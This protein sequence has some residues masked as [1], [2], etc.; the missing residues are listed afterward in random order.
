MEGTSLSPVAPDKLPLQLEG[1]SPVN[2]DVVFYRNGVPY[3]N[4]RT[5]RKCPTLAAGKSIPIFIRDIRACVSLKKTY[6]P[7]V[8]F[9]L[10]NKSVKMLGNVPIQSVTICGQWTAT[11]VFQLPNK[12]DLRFIYVK[13]MSSQTPITC[14]VD[15]VVWSNGKIPRMLEENC[16]LLVTGRIKYYKRDN[17]MEMEARAIH[18]YHELNFLEK[19]IA[20]AKFVLEHRR[21]FLA[22]YDYHPEKTQLLTDRLRRDN[23]VVG[24]FPKPPGPINVR[25]VI[26]KRYTITRYDTL[27]N[28][29]KRGRKRKVPKSKFGL[30]EHFI[31]SSKIRILLWILE[32]S[33][34]SNSYDKIAPVFVETR[35]FINPEIRRQ[36]FNKSVSIL[37]KAG[38]LKRFE[39][40][41][42]QVSPAFV[43]AFDA[44]AL[45]LIRLHHMR[46][47]ELASILEEAEKHAATRDQFQKFLF[48]RIAKT[49]VFKFKLA[50]FINLKSRCAPTFSDVLWAELNQGI[51]P[52]QDGFSCDVKYNGKMLIEWVMV[53]KYR[54][55]GRF[56][57]ITLGEKFGGNDCNQ[58]KEKIVSMVCSEA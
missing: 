55:A 41:N 22:R 44:A 1:E 35:P 8:P 12:P 3:Y 52:E 51:I 13:D 21:M 56:T 26:P 58:M 45:E 18:F 47:F 11:K 57:Y 38:I 4:M 30:S 7:Y 53:D 2:K 5:L 43:R 6:A 39:R 16:L 20:W 48:E 17:T 54:W 34:T 36:L 31:E 19:E 50:K 29:R 24:L 9:S 33:T 25:K 28:R 37:Q 15:S 42:I 46:K 10:S 40:T 32:R 23:N 14:V 27:K 49:Q